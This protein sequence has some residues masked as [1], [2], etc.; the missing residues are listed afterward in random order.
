MVV[1]ESKVELE[2]GLMKH[3][4]YANCIESIMYAIVSS[5]SDI[6]YGVGLINRFMN[7]PGKSHWQVAKW[8]L[9]YLKGILDVKLVYSR[10]EQQSCKLIGYCDSNYAGDLN[11]R[12]SLYS[13]HW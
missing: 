7:N 8:L 2:A 1:K 10:N 4:S 6:T 9:C 12:R 13:Y 11:K 5:R 3:V